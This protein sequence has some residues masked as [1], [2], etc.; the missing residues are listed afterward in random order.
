MGVNTS[1]ESIFPIISTQVASMKAFVK[2][3]VRFSAL[4]DYKTN[5]R[6]SHC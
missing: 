1:T 6:Q 5:P 3:K 2:E 4:L